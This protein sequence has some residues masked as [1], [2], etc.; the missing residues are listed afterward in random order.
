MQTQLRA[1]SALGW[2][3]VLAFCPAVVRASATAVTAEH[4]RPCPWLMSVLRQ[5]RMQ[6]H[7]EC[8]SV[9]RRHKREGWSFSRWAGVE[10]KPGKQGGCSTRRLAKLGFSILFKM[11][12]RALDSHLGTIHLEEALCSWLCVWLYRCHVSLATALAGKLVSVLLL[13]AINSPAI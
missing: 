12:S 2:D 10:R 5:L 4:C 8:N 6:R 13:F 11:E 7:V 9:L 3:P 1:L